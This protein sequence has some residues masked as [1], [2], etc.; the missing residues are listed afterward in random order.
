MAS[1]QAHHRIPTPLLGRHRAAGVIVETASY[2]TI[3]AGGPIA[4]GWR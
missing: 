4:K 1:A 3:E 2:A